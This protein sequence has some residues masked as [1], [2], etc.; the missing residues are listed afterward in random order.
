MQRSDVFSMAKSCL[1][2]HWDDEPISPEAWQELSDW[3][4]LFKRKLG[5]IVNHGPRKDPDSSD[6]LRRCSCSCGCEKRILLD[7]GRCCDCNL[8]AHRGGM[9]L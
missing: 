5:R 1:Q 3:I 9:A 4:D 2:I 7:D 6:N 8:G